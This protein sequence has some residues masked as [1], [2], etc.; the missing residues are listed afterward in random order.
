GKYLEELTKGRT[1]DAMKKLMGLAPKTAVVIREGNEVEIS[2]DEVIEGDIIIVK[3]GEKMPVDGVV[4]HGWTAVDDAMLTG[5]S[6]PIE[7]YVVNQIIEASINKDG[8]I[9][10]EATKVGKDTALSQIIQL[11]ED[12]QGSKAPIAKMADVISG[13]FVPI[14]IVIAILSGLA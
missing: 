13:Y 8:T 1:S 7:K 10:Y 14:V 3:P 4:T 9:Q 2:V 6:I 5:D 11:V 12:A